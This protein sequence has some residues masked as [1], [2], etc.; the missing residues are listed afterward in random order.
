ML[1]L[2]RANTSPVALLSYHLQ[3][4]QD[5]TLY[6]G[7]L[8]E[9]V[10]DDLL[11]E[12]FVQVGPLVSIHMPTDKVSGRHQGYAFVEFRTEDDAEY[13]LKVIN[14]VRLFGKAMRVKKASSDK[15]RSSDVGANLFIGNLGPEVDEKLLYDTFSAFGGI[16]APPKIMRDPDSGASKGFG[17]VNFDS[18][19]ASDSAIEAMN[20]QFLAGRPVVVQY[21]Y[22]KST[23]GGVQ[24]ERHGSQAERILAAAQRSSA[25]LRPHTL[26]ALAPGQ[27]HSSV[28]QAAMVGTGRAQTAPMLAPT[29]AL[30]AALQPPPL[31]AG[32]PSLMPPPLPLMGAGAAAAA[33]PPLPAGYGMPAGVPGM[34]MAPGAGFPPGIEMGGG[35]IGGLPMMPPPGMM[36]M[37]GAGPGMQQHLQQP[38]PLPHMMMQR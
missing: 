6:V 27:V 4:N 14:M 20:G 29:A 36:M 34:G 31:P 28:P 23:T 38:P 37:A 2:H 25:A 24:G 15:T 22:K 16:V 18:F 12:L 8:D 19:E 17:F 3:R 11:W 10:D 1:W 21:A 32:L 5:A 35:M 9:K 33:P 13:A 30:P 26:F 7:G